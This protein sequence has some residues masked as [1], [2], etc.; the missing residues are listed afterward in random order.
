MSSLNAF[1]A[2]LRPLALLCLALLIAAPAARAETPAPTSEAAR[3]AEVNAALE[4]GF[5]AGTR[6][7]AA[8][9]LLDQATLQ[10]PAGYLF[11]PAA[12]AKRILRAYGNTVNGDSYQGL[13]LKPDADWTVV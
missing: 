6:G 9:K 10:L 7:P 8:V 12:E 13:V 11:I 5:K 4:A 2:A 1:A 3:Q